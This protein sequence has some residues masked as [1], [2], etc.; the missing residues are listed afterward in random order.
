MKKMLLSI[1]LLVLCGFAQHSKVAIYPCDIINVQSLNPFFTKLGAIVRDSTTVSVVHIGDSHIQA[2]VFSGTVRKKLQNTFGNAGRG[3]VFPYKIAKSYGALD[4]QFSHTGTWQYCHIKR[5]YSEC[6]LGVAGFTVTPLG[7]AAFSIDVASKAQTDAAFNKVTLLDND[8]SFLPLETIGDFSTS[9]ENRHTVIC[10]DELQ[11]SLT[12]TPA[13]EKDTLPELQGMVLENSRPGVLYH[14]MGINGSTVSQYLRSKHFEE[15]IND[16]N[17]SLVIISFGTNDSYTSSSKFCVKCFKEEYRTL[18]KRVRSKNPHA[19]ILLTIPPDHYLNRKYPSNNV[20]P[21]RDT[22]IGLAIEEGVAV[23]DLY[24]A[25]GG[26]NAI[27]DW[28][29]DELAR[30]DLIHFTL[31]GYELQGEM[32]YNALM[33][34]YKGQ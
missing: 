26:K 25:M 1:F 2:D 12:F 8:G 22:L 28:K 17:A 14:A 3:F 21:V 19:S 10:F 27:L 15:Q 5:G 31:E 33:R 24:E 6:N 29:N 16:L 13:Y 34:G 20:A 32:L 9:K 30:A 18:I 4:V 23:W 11:D 7:N